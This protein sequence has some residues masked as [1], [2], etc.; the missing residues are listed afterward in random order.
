M[1]FLVNNKMFPFEKL[2]FPLGTKE[3]FEDKKKTFLNR[4]LHAAN[5]FPKQKK[6]FD[7][8]GLRKQFQ[9]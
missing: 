7:D 9:T 3:V 1:S 2:D 4:M 5:G 8:Q 6:L